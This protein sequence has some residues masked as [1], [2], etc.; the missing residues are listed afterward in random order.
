MTSTASTAL[1]GARARIDESLRS[2]APRGEA[3]PASQPYPS[4]LDLVALIEF[5]A[6][7]MRRELLCRWVATL[8]AA[9]TRSGVRATGAASCEVMER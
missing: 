5:R 7:A 2:R 8:W 9:V 4:K 3:A 1:K 6:R